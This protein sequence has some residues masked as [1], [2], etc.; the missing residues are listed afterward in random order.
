MK[1]SVIPVKLFCH[2]CVGRNPFHWW[3]YIPRNSIEWIP[4]CTE[5]T[6]C[7]SYPYLF[8]SPLSGLMPD[9]PPQGASNYI[10]SDALLFP[11]PGEN[12][13]G[14]FHLDS[15]I[16]CNNRSRVCINYPRRFFGSKIL[17]TSI[18]NI[19]WISVETLLIYILVRSIE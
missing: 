7:D 18:N 13:K 5:M 15:L 2:S 11:P 4:V 6:E 9:F 12:T 17:V 14:G 1:S 3:C 19:L 10:Q 16:Y 8:I